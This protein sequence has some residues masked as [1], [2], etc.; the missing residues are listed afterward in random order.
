MRVRVT[1][2]SGKNEITGVREDGV[3]LIRVTAPPENGKANDAVCKLLAT[4]LGVPKSAVS[5][6]R[7]QTARDKTVT[8]DGDPDLGHLLHH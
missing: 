6:T 5:V 4:E 2:R 1:P 3:V 8:V 7:G